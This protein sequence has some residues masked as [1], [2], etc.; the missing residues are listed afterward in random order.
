M[1][2][3]S[4]AVADLY[5]MSQ[6]PKEGPDWVW[7]LAIDGRIIAVLT[8]ARGDLTA[9]DGTGFPPRAVVVLLCGVKVDGRVTPP[10]IEYAEAYLKREPQLKLFR[11][12]LASPRGLRALGDTLE[13][14]PVALHNSRLHDEKAAAG[15][16]YGVRP[17]RTMDEREVKL[18]EAKCDK[19]ITEAQQ[20]FDDGRF[21]LIERDVKLPPKG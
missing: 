21:E 9:N 19:Q 13:V 1:D 12:G 3:E 15:T 4:R 14:D 18:L 5:F 7:S 2:T 20:L 8:A 16:A 10:L 11:S 6:D 17:V